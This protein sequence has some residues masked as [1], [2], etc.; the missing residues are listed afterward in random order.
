MHSSGLMPPPSS[1]PPPLVV[2]VFPYNGEPLLLF[3]LEY[4]ASV[5]DIFVTVESKITFSGQRKSFFYLDNL[6][7]ETGA[8]V[9]KLRVAG[10]W[11]NYKLDDLP[12]PKSFDRTSRRGRNAS[13][14]AAWARERY[15]RDFIM[16]RIANVTGRRPY[17]M[18]CM[19]IDEIPRKDYVALLP[20]AYSMIE[21]PLRLE[22]RSYMFSF[23]WQH[24]ARGSDLWHKPFLVTDLVLGDLLD[25]KQ[26]L[27]TFRV[28]PASFMYLKDAGWHCSFCLPADDIVRTIHSFSRLEL[29][30][31]EYTAIVRIN[32]SIENGTHL[33]ARH[34]ATS[35]LRE[36]TCVSGAEGAD[37]P[38]CPSCWSSATLAYLVQR[39]NRC[40][41]SPDTPSP[42]PPALK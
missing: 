18:M 20:Q 8:A 24:V 22:L 11:V 4:L 10:K 39:D 32:A 37:V 27:D 23:R 35:T 2:D 21:S 41:A 16:D 42:Q 14:E 19:D 29:D 36:R 3:R 28:S 17:V 40:E 34:F 12:L 7:A 33:F 5:V 31:K 38:S 26:T 1:A 13:I 30:R 25:N 15:Q 6:D 9:N